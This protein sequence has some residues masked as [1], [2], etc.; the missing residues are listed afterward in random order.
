MNVGAKANILRIRHE[1]DKKVY[2][3]FEDGTI[4]VISAV[5][6]DNPEVSFL[7]LQK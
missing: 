3:C 6:L 7:D 5:K 2:G 1:Q 4:K